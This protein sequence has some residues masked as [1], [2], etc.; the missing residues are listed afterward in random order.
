MAEP[1]KHFYSENK[2][3][4]LFCDSGC[5]MTQELPDGAHP[6]YTELTNNTYQDIFGLKGAL[7][8]SLVGIQATSNVTYALFNA[9]DETVERVQNGAYLYEGFNYDTVAFF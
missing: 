5:A 1:V 2:F 8:H 7:M 9:T 6:T 4:F 3:R